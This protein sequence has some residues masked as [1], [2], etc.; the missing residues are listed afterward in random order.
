M[1]A[2]REGR[3]GGK[4]GWLLCITKTKGISISVLI[5]ECPPV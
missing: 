3:E 4:E 5:K 2:L 1:K